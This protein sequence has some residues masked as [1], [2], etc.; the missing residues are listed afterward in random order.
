ETEPVYHEL[1]IANHDGKLVTA[2]YWALVAMSSP[3]VLRVCLYILMRLDPISLR[4][5]IS[6]I[7]EGTIAAAS[8]REHIAAAA[9]SK[10]ISELESAFKTSLLV[11]TNKGIRPTTAGIALS[12]LARRALRELDEVAVHMK[13]YA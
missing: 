4:L 3:I 7:E 6:V 12:S 2:L 1:A 11:R 10:R 13:E 8:E 5:F 9:I